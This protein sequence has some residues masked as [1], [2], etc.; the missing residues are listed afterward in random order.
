[1]GDCLSQITLQWLCFL[2]LSSALFRVRFLSEGRYL[3]NPQLIWCRNCTIIDSCS[4]IHF[5]LVFGTWVLLFC[6]LKDLCFYYNLVRILGF[7]GGSLRWV[8]GF[9]GWF[10][11]SENGLLMDLWKV[12]PLWLFLFGFCCYYCGLEVFG[13]WVG[14]WN[15]SS[16]PQCLSFPMCVSTVYVRV[17]FLAF[18][19]RNEKMGRSLRLCDVHWRTAFLFLAEVW[20]FFF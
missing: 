17:W 20:V 3:S 4:G 2:S 6:R 11:V 8:F 5:L 9:L 19:S 7:W 18:N 16:V 13:W 1:M 12:T 10:N 14:S 15:L